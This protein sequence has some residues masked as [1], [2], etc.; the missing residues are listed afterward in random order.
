MSFRLWLLIWLG[1]ITINV[2]L[3][4]VTI[5]EWPFDRLVF[6]ALA[7]ATLLTL[8]LGCLVGFFWG[9]PW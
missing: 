2:L 1:A 4:R 8:V 5:G 7:K 3:Y 9:W 6:G